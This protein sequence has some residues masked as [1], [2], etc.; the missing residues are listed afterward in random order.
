MRFIKKTGIFLTRF[1]FS[2]I[3]IRNDKKPMISFKTTIAVTLTIL[4][5]TFILLILL[6]SNF[7]EE[8][9]IKAYSQSLPVSVNSDQKIINTI[10]DELSNNTYVIISLTITLFILGYFLI[11]LI[12]RKGLRPLYELKSAFEQNIYDRRKWENENVNTELIIFIN[13]LNNTLFEFNELKK[14]MELS[15]IRTKT[16]IQR[17]HEVIKKLESKVGIDTD[18]LIAERNNA[19]STCESQILFL[20]NMSHEIRTPL[21]AVIGFAESIQDSQSVDNKNYRLV[22]AIINNGNHLLRVVNDILDMSKIELGKL[23]LENISCSPFLILH[24]IKVVFE[25]LAK[26]K[27]L[28]LTFKYTFPLPKTIC[29]DPTRIKQILINVCGNA[30]KFTPKG[31]ITIVIRFNQEKKQINFIV[32]DTGIGMHE[33]Q[34]NKLFMPFIQATTSTTREYGGT[35]LGLYIS[36]QLAKKL[37]GTIF[38]ESKINQGSTFN[39]SIASGD[40]NS[41]NMISSQSQIPIETEN[42]QAIIVPTVKGK[43]LLAEDNPDNQHLMSLLI[44]KTSAELSIANNGKEAIKLINENNFDLVLMDIKMPVMDGMEA[45]SLIRETNH[46]L[47]VIALTANVMKTDVDEYLSSGF[48]DHVPKPINRAKLY[49]I[50]KKYLRTSTHTV[51][52]EEKQKK[53]YKEV[54]ILYA[55]DN[56]DNQNIVRLLLKK[57]NIPLDIAENGEVAVDMMIENDY[58]LILMDMQMPVMSGLEATIMIRQSGFKS[59]IIALTAN[60]YKSDID[61][62]RRAGCNNWIAKPIDRKLFYKLIDQYLYDIPEDEKNKSPSNQIIA[63]KDDPEY[64]ILVEKFLSRLPKTMTTMADSLK[65]KDWEQ[66]VFKLHTL[67]G[68]GGNYGFNELYQAAEIFEK[69][70]KEKHYHQLETDFKNLNTIVQQVTTA[71]DIA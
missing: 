34:I 40:I 7:N 24:D 39:I 6:F 10:R 27:G 13:F 71:K 12:I 1:I 48:N 2:I 8:I 29:T 68:T 45:I 3:S 63:E 46:K 23:E 25:S 69:H 20:S 64:D 11:I 55:E 33:Q 59:P 57:K 16:S 70:V 19:L 65:E 66:L 50:I 51:I 61:T 28:D 17:H 60:T 56:V 37:G 9:A 54:K 31:S 67:K 36:M 14:N 32:T 4:C 38:V 22:K 43:I 62:Y 47:P 58:D 26:E 52:T 30:I 49:E 44:G 18:K 53:S 35:G 41:L 21:T 15:D 42:N 5:A